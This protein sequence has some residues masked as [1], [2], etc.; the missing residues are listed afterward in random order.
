MATSS[1]IASN[2]DVLHVSYGH[3]R[4]IAR[5]QDVHDNS[6]IGALKHDCW[7]YWG[8]ISA[9]LIAAESGELIGLHS[10]WDDQT[11]MRRVIG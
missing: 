11:G 6:E 3:Y 1:P 10:S 7:T 4:G 9:P 2:Y 8:H 5:G